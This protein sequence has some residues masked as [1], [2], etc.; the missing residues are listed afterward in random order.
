VTIWELV[1]STCTSLGGMI[2]YRDGH[3]IHAHFGAPIGF[4]VGAGAG[5]ALPYAVTFLVAAV[6]SAVTKKPLFPPRQ[7]RG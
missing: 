3:A 1:V 5:F 6:R 4:M 7:P 2:G